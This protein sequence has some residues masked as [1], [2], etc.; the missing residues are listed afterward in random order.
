MIT[1]DNYNSSQI[2]LLQLSMPRNAMYFVG[3]ITA[4]KIL[5]F[6]SGG[7]ED[8][9]LLAC[10]TDSLVGIYR[11]LR[12]ICSLHPQGERFEDED[13]IFLQKII[14]LIR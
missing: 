1:L 9:C 7:C 5:G 14:K 12:G 10:G 6:Y 3:S 11:C 8:Y 4:F 2:S 13:C